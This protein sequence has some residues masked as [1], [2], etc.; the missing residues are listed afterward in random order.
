MKERIFFAGCF[1][2]VMAASTGAQTKVSATGKCDKPEPRY[3]IEV[4]PS[5]S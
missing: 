3:S 4:G 2:V 1:V 5:W